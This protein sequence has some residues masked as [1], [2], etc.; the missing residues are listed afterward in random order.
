MRL[1]HNIVLRL[2]ENNEGRGHVKAMD[3]FFSSIGLFKELLEKWIYAT[4]S[5]GANCVVLPNAL[6]NI[7]TF[8]RSTQETLEWCIQEFI[9]ISS[10][11]WEDKQP[12]LLISTSAVPI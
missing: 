4:G 11:M 7:K 8:T 6:K 2:L 5:I 12:V 3:N 9:E 10:I 1:V